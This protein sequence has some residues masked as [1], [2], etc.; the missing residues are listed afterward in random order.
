MAE[1][2]VAPDRETLALVADSYA[3]KHLHVQA[4]ELDWFLERLQCC[5][6]VFLGEETTMAFG[7]K[8]SG[9]KHVLSTSGAARY[10]GGL[11]VHKYM[12]LSTW[13]RS[14][15][16]GVKPVAEATARI[17]RLE[18]MDGQAWTEDIRLVKY[19]PDESFDLAAFR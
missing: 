17:S 19:F 2:M 13:Q 18:G 3:P 15:R 9:P 7:D 6:S 8:S 16:D 12:K 11:G 1:L 14:S 10:I 4:A 5:G